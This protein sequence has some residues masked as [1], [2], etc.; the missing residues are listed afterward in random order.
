MS[1]KIKILVTGDEGRATIA[2][3]MTW[4]LM[5][6]NV[7]PLYIGDNKNA[8]QNLAGDEMELSRLTAKLVNDDQPVFE[9]DDSGKDLTAQLAATTTEL[10]TLMIEHE[11]LK[12]QLKALQDKPAAVVEH[13]DGSGI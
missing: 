11:E 13:K 2:G 6:F 8:W 3:L 1:K 4:A 10:A 5:K 12:K 7:R 9:I